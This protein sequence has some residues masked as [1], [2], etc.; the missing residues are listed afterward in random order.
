MLYIAVLLGK[1]DLTCSFFGGRPSS[2]EQGEA[3]SMKQQTFF[4]RNTRLL[5]GVSKLCPLSCALMGNV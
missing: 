5:A 4:L 1:R 3:H 2:A